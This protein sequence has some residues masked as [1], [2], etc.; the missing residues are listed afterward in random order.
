M[1]AYGISR[2]SSGL[3]VSYM[4]A[5]KHTHMIGREAAD[6]E[7]LLTKDDIAKR[8]KLTRRGIECLVARRLIPVIRISRRCVRF[9]WEAVQAALAR[10]EVKE[11]GRR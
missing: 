11:I 10:V 9:S 8:L 6:S 4:N 5:R 2:S 1:Q 3:T 7:G